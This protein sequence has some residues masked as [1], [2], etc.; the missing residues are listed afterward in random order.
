MRANLKRR[1]DQVEVV[2][3]PRR[4]EPYRER[5][6]VREWEWQVRTLK[7]GEKSL[8]KVTELWRVEAGLET[9]QVEVA[10]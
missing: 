5:N 4:E 6:G 1:N 8:D 2:G 9:D 7:S 3:Q 10:C